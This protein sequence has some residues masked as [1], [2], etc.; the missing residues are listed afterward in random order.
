MPIIILTG[1]IATGKSTVT[2]YLQQQGCPV[3]DADLIARSVVEPGSA[4]LARIRATFGPDVIHADGTLDRDA[5]GTVIF[6]D[7]AARTQLDQLLHPL[8]YQEID[9]QINQLQ[10]Q[11]QRVIFVDIPLFYE[12]QSELPH[13]E[14]WVVVTSEKEQLSRLMKR[15]DYSMQ[16]A[17]ERI[18]SQIPIKNKRELADIVIDNSGPLVATYQQVDAQLLRLNP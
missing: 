9:R 15:N 8:I 3:I 4:G 11:G 16:Q 13:D 6:R 2:R 17:Q 14:V 7:E 10:E 5:L 12:T 18:A 1:S